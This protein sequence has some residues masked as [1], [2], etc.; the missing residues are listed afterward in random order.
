M[1][2]N[3][4]LFANT[5]FTIWFSYQHELWKYFHENPRRIVFKCPTAASQR[6]CPNV[7]KHKKASEFNV[8]LTNKCKG[9]DYISLK[10]C[11][12]YV[13][14]CPHLHPVFFILD[15][16][17]I[18]LGTQFRA[19]P[20]PYGVAC[21]LVRSRR[22][23]TYDLWWIN[24]WI[25]LSLWFL[26]INNVVSL[27]STGCGSYWNSSHWWCLHHL[28]SIRHEDV[29]K[30]MNIRM[31]VVIQTRA[32]LTAAWQPSQC[33]VH[34]EISAEITGSFEKLLIR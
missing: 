26:E 19:A 4:L 12:I 29:A 28:C 31:D 30:R 17:T 11:G 10:I 13:E 27:L 34:T 5:P 7:H 21:T 3:N 14:T 20:I 22:G 33:E 25:L 32:P 2:W 1:Q 9:L 24:I 6:P 18:Y 8:S 23:V 16:W 15:R